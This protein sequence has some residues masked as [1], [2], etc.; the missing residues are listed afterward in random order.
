MEEYA[1][2]LTMELLHMGKN[3]QVLCER[4]VDDP[5]NDNLDIIEL[6]ESMKKPRWLAH[7]L[8]AKKVRT[9]VKAFCHHNTIIH[10]HERIS[11][12]HVTTIHSTLYNFPS[13]KNFPSLRNY[14]NEFIERRELNSPNVYCIVPVSSMILGQI[15][16]KHFNISQKLTAP[17][18]PGVSPINVRQKIFNPD[19][20]VIGFM[21]KEWKRKG[22]P[23]VIEVWRKLRQRI[24]LSKL[25]LAG[26]SP[27]ESLGLSEE[28]K[29]HVRLLGWQVDKKKFF[30]HVD[31]LLHP[32][33]IEAYGMVIAEAMTLSIPVL[34]S[35]QCGASSDVSCDSG[36]VLDCDAPSSDWADCV[37][38]VLDAKRPS[39]PFRRT[40]ATVSQEY[41]ET[42]QSIELGY[43]EHE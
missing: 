18:S 43:N 20:P 39:K 12:H 34:C 35:S 3:V 11:C 16:K 26:F 8:F 32:A 27:T 6:G 9:W 10:S 31:L 41:V 14:M 2:R 40:W 19:C 28:E 1:Y 22:L 7:L 4:V 33:R 23:K 13:K 21:G 5:G 25:C 15:T 37:A 42:Y 24:P 30:D 17:V 38:R 36:K 29:K